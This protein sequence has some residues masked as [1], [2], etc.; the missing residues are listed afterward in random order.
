MNYTR[1]PHTKLDTKEVAHYGDEHG[2]YNT[3]SYTLLSPLCADVSEI[4]KNLKIS[5]DLLT[6]P[7]PQNPPSRRKPPPPPPHRLSPPHVP[8]NTAP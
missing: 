1:L 3:H 6:H 8:P 4:S 5:K 2:I 7:R